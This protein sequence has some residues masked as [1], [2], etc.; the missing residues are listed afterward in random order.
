MSLS[1]RRRRSGFT[2]IE[3][4]VVIAIIATLMGLLLPAVQKVREAAS[5]A[6]SQNNLKQIA[7]AFHNHNAQVGYMPHNGWANYTTTEWTKWDGWAGF[8]DPNVPA[9][10]QRGSWAAVLL[11]FLEQNNVYDNRTYGA[12][13]KVYN[14]AARRPSDVLDIGSATA[15]NGPAATTTRFFSRTDYAL[16]GFLVLNADGPPTPLHSNWVAMVPD[17]VMTASAS[18]CDFDTT[19]GGWQN[20]PKLRIDDFKDGTSNTI[21]VGEKALYTNDVVNGWG[22]WANDNPVW[23]GGTWGTARG[24]TRL[25]R[26]RV[27]PDSSTPQDQR[28]DHSYNCGGVNRSSA[29]FGSP[30]SGGVNFAF[31]DGSVRTLPF[32]TGNNFRLMM[33]T[34]LTPKGSTANASIE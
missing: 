8:F 26:D 6:Q 9:K 17:T 32:G 22:V 30:F 23:S 28:A 24:G 34:L 7:L 12:D 29:D 18:D 1:L 19:T 20:V 2:L 21:L 3:L 11:P 13:L 10:T 14:L 15:N 25:I 5:R 16:N 4:L 31:G 33:R 27:S